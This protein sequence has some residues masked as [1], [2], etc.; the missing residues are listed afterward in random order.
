LTI[1]KSGHIM[2]QTQKIK[3]LQSNLQ[4]GVR[5]PTGGKRR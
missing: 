3:Y 1:I 4:G 5:F 2:N